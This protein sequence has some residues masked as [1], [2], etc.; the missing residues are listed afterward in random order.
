[1]TV[2]WCVSF[3][4]YSETNKWMTKG[5]FVAPSEPMK[6]HKC[7]KALHWSLQQLFKNQHP[8]CFQT[9]FAANV[10]PAEFTF[11]WPLECF[12]AKKS[13]WLN[14]AGSLAFFYFF[15]QLN[16]LSVHSQIGPM[17]SQDRCKFF[18][19]DLKF[20]NSHDCGCISFC[21]LYCVLLEGISTNFKHTS[22]FKVILLKVYY[23]ILWHKWGKVVLSLYGFKRVVWILINSFQNVKKS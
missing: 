5:Y 9:G 18:W 11:V 2:S 17:K 21:M 6:V 19:S 8:K 10:Y 14:W 12:V 15:F 1:M 13:L 23:Y 7:S 20:F 22:G 3:S 4:C 16:S